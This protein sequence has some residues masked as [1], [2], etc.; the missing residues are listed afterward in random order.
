MGRRERHKLVIHLC[1]YHLVS[2]LYFSSGHCHDCTVVIMLGMV[3]VC[4]GKAV[5]ISMA[6]ANATPCL[7]HFHCGAHLC[8][9]QIA[10]CPCL[11]SAAPVD[12]HVYSLLLYACNCSCVNCI[13]RFK[14]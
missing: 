4:G 2:S 11:M 8:R 9:Y 12:V 10:R 13:L 5:G 6:V 14:L 1:A 3:N 7:Q